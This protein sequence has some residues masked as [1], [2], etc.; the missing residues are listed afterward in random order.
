MWEQLELAALIQEVWADNQ[1]SCTITFKPDMEGK[2]IANALNYFQYKLKGISFLPLCT[3]GY[4]Q[5]P[6]EEITLEKYNDMIQKAQPH[7]GRQSLKFFREQAVFL[8]RRGIAAGMVVYQYDAAGLSQQGRFKYVPW[9]DCNSR[10][11]L[12][13]AELDALLCRGCEP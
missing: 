7:A 11:T 2:D 5:M 3:S 10:S 9:I 12:L 8:R 6:Y 13:C 1:V 4:P